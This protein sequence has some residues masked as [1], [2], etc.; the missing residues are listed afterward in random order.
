MSHTTPHPGSGGAV[1]HAPAVLDH[2]A[3]LV[4]LARR[5]LRAWRRN[6]DLRA[7]LRGLDDHMLADIG[8]TR[9]QVRNEID[10]PFWRP[11]DLDRRRR[12]R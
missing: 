3:G 4:R 12:R 7:E 9:F 11:V 2:L 8:L 5:K 6:A 10:R 1:G